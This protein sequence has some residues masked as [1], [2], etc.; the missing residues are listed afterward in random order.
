MNLPLVFLPDVRDDIDEAYI[1]YED[2]RAS[3]SWRGRC[4][5]AGDR[6]GTRLFETER[7]FPHLLPNKPDRPILR[8]LKCS[9]RLEAGA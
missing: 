9:N 5:A 6:S 4:P 2:Q 1:W 7:A 3:S 8:I